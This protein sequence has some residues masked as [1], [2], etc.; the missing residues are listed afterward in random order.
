MGILVEILSCILQVLLRVGN[1]EPAKHDLGF[2]VLDRAP[3]VLVVSPSDVERENDYPDCKRPPFPTA[4]LA[5]FSPATVWTVISR[6][7]D[8][9]EKLHMQSLPAVWR[10]MMVMIQLM[11]N[12]RVR[13]IKVRA[14]SYAHF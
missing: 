2:L 5:P 11:P 1:L 14:L 9:V 7:L 13:K 12:I 4:D 3:P 8:P 10:A 6:S